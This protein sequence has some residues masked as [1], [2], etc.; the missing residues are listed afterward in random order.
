MRRRSMSLTSCRGVSE[1]AQE[2]GG[3]ARI[4]SHQIKHAPQ[5]RPQPP[6]PRGDCAQNSRVRVRKSTDS[7][8]TREQRTLPIF[9]LPGPGACVSVAQPA[10]HDHRASFF[11][12]TVYDVVGHDVCAILWVVFFANIALE[13]EGVV[14][15]SAV[16]S[17]V[18]LVPGVLY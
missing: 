3:A 11:N 8:H 12:K 7:A 1:V 10:H 4:R 15:R 17:Q 6:D 14:H 9:W 5:D 18:F 2:G 13:K 16:P